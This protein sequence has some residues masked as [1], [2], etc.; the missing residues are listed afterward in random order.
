[1]VAIGV[2]I[3]AALAGRWVRIEHAKR[4]LLIGLVMGLLTPCMTLVH[5]LMWAVP[6][7]ILIGATAGFFVVPMNALL[8][9]RGCRVL[10]AGR[11]IAVQGFNENL[12]VLAMVSIYSG[13]LA[14]D[15]PVNWLIWG[16]GLLVAAIMGLVIVRDNVRPQSPWSLAGRT[17]E[18]R[19]SAP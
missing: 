17:G 18:G 7:L 14:L 19:Q 1:V 12:S 15:V 8:Q 2:V 11:S 13:L 6:L 4:V 10:S 5:S 9:D 3:G 16:F